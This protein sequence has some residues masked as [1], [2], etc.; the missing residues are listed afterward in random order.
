MDKI[1]VKISVI[2]PTYNRQKKIKKCLKA[3]KNQLLSKDNYEI[4]IIDDNSDDNTNEIVKDIA[5]KKELNIIYIK[6]SKKSGPAFSRNKGIKKA[7]FNIIALI[8]SDCIPEKNWLLKI[9]KFYENNRDIS[10]IGG[11]T[12]T[13]GLKSKIIQFMANGA[14]HSNI[15]GKNTVIFF[16]TCNVAV[17]KDIFK[18]IL[19][20][21]QFKFAG[22]EDLEF[23]W[24]IYKRGYVFF[25]DD[26]LKVFHDKKIN[27][28]EFI[29]HPF[30]YAKEN[31]LV[32][33]KHP[34]HPFLK[35][36]IIKNGFFYFFI[37]KQFIVSPV[38]AFLL[39]QKF[40]KEENYFF[41]I[42]YLYFLFFRIAY[43]CGYLNSYINNKRLII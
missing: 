21:E 14:I 26:S 34:E 41:G 25:Y 27:F 35:D 23:F 4:I 30:V 43:L 22:G 37:A 28:F 40:K 16:T 3:F 12:F 17:K 5:D 8:D 32:K 31:F 13:E 39:S 36:L 15:K 29:M 2:I 18:N 7:S 20:D 9:S 11:Y 33:L 38:L 24:N 19:F 42:A 6:N 1:T 10:V